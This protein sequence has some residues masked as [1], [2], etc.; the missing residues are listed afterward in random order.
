MVLRAIA[1]NCHQD[2]RNLFNHKSKGISG[3]TLENAKI[4]LEFARDLRKLVED[5]EEEMEILTNKEL[6]ES[7]KENK[8]EKKGN[9]KI[10]DNLDDLEREL[11][12]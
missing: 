12:L 11:Q 7:I 6:M 1:T 3:D 10:F 8:R 5:F 4:L 9:T 2:F